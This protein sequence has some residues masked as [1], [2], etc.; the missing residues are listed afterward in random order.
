MNA[1]R[2]HL[3]R[4]SCCPCSGFGALLALWA[5]SSATWSKNLPSPAKTWEVSK[6]YVLEPFAKRGELDQGILRFAWYSLVLVAKGYAIALLIGT[7]LG[8]I[9]GLVEAVRQ[10]LRP[11]H[12]GAAA[13][14]AAGLAAAGAGAVPEVAAGGAVHHRGLRD[15]AHGAQHRARAC[16]RSPRTT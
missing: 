10:E 9:L 4:A 16:A 8:F 12:P 11:D 3:S 1:L 13:G 5:F 14:L 6:H 7:P 15:V 2:K